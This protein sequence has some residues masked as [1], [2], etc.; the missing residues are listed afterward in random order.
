M[1]LKGTKATCGLS[2]FKNTFALW[3]GAPPNA[4]KPRGS[5][6]FLQ[7]PRQ[8]YWINS[9]ACDPLATAAA[10]DGAAE[11]GYGEFRILLSVPVVLFS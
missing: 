6:A 3:Q 7:V 1:S 5:E 10:Q 2:A 4:G 11:A 8:G 9:V